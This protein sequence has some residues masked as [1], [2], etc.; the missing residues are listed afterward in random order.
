MSSIERE[1]EKAVFRAVTTSLGAIMTPSGEKAFLSQ[2]WPG[3]TLNPTEYANP[4]SPSNP[5]GSQFSCERFSALANRI[6]KISAVFSDSGRLVGEAYEMI[7]T[8]ASCIPGPSG[9]T[10]SQLFSSAQND[11]RLSR[12]ASSQS[13]GLFYYATLSNPSN[14]ADEF[15]E[16]HWTQ[17]NQVIEINNSL[18]TLLLKYL[19]VSIERPWFNP[20]LF[21]LPGWSLFT[22]PGSISNGSTIGNSGFFALLPVSMLLARDISIANINNELLFKSKAI[23]VIAYISQVVHESPPFT[24]QWIGK[25]EDQLKDELPSIGLSIVVTLQ[26]QTGLALKKIHEDRSFGIYNSPPA[27]EVTAHSGHGFSVVQELT[28]GP[29]G[30]IVYSFAPE[31]YLLVYWQN[32][33]SSVN[34]GVASFMP[35]SSS[36]SRSNLLRYSS[37]DG[38]I[39]GI[40]GFV[41]DASI[42]R[43]YNKVVYSYN[44]SNQSL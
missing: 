38:R 32:F 22:G 2:L 26:N 1:V 29:E 35:T 24:Y 9:S 11:L 19:N 42:P 6:P 14:W 30:W 23:Q 25:T 37:V 13:P 16:D 34:R 15:H 10:A 20:S 18:A 39:G 41:C 31:Y 3:Q 33:Y 27:P 7:V 4:W 28:S 40:D 43:G 5:T 36:L 44:I 8:N 17:I 12:L 21:D